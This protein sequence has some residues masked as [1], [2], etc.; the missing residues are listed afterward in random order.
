MIGPA[1]LYLPH[2]FAAAGYAVAI[3]LLVLSTTMFLWSSHC[4]LESWRI[5][6]EKLSRR[7]FSRRHKKVHLSYPELAYR[8]FGSRG[9]R[10][11]QIGISMMQSGV[12]ITYLIFV[13][14]NLHTSARL[15]FGWD[16]STNWCLLFMMAVQIPLSWI[17]D[18]RKFK[19]TNLLGNLLIFY[20]WIACLGFALYALVSGTKRRLYLNDATTLIIKNVT[21]K[22][23]LPPG[24]L[25]TTV[26]LAYSF[27]VVFTFPLQNFP[28]L[29]I[30]HRFTEKVLVNRTTS[31]YSKEPD[32]T[33]H[34]MNIV[35]AMVVV[36]LSVIAVTTM[37][38]LDKVVGIMGSLLGIPIAFMMP[39]LIHN[40]LGGDSVGKFR[41][42]GNHVCVG[43]GF[44]AVA[45]STIAT[46]M[47]WS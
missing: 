23:S 30:V 45:I 15:L 24:K 2:A 3:P 1:I 13:P 35:S 6:N 9:E 38:V 37:D 4:L 14:Q 28:S 36:L 29:E 19:T 27:A 43:L 17:R 20:G 11:V 21:L 10:L 25:A 42:M 41:K 26:Q 47:Q 12:C 39:P 32:R 44:V 46:I 22:L 40:K 18:I 31:S 7:S 5:E 33:H 34:V 16:V 8:S